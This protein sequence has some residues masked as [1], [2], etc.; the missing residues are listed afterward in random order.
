MFHPMG[1]HSARVAV[2]LALVM[3]LLSVGA[4]GSKESD[5]T[6]TPNPTPTA[7]RTGPSVVTIAG[8][9]FEAEIAHTPAARAQGLSG[10]ESLPPKTGMLFVFPSGR[11]SSFW[12]KGMMM[13]LDFVW[14][15]KDCAV[16]AT[17]ARVPPPAPGLP[18]SALRMYKPSAPAAYTFEINAGEVEEFG[19][20]PG[21]EVRFSGF[22]SDVSG[23]G[24]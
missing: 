22:P 1:L 23:A 15:G 3:A 4:C 14:I 16:V 8:V 21:D 7:A 10:R 9:A 19:I 24:C 5:W 6:P 2:V 17:T 12:M 20:R 18:D 13:S 11:A